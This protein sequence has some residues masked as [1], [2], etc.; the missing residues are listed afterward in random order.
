MDF[1]RTW[2]EYKIGF[3]DLKREF[4]LGNDN[5][6]LLT[7]NQDQK[8]KIKLVSSDGEVAFADYDLLW[9]EDEIGKYRLHTGNYT[10][11]PV[12]GKYMYLFSQHIH[13]DDLL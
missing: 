7:K 4:W 9:I 5:L 11:D 8:V 2:D 1:Y 13:H 3:G 10:G 6:H 12:P